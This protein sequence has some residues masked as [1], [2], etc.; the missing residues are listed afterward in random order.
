VA[1]GLGTVGAE[2]NRD[3]GFR[4]LG[5][6][7]RDNPAYRADCNSATARNLAPAVPWLR[8]PGRLAR[9]RAAWRWEVEKKLPA[10]AAA[11]AHHN[12]SLPAQNSGALTYFTLYF[13]SASH[14][15]RRGR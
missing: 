8:P 2:R 10:R 9:L 11:A 15:A 7:P 12:M 14:Q 4:R 13:T 5:R 6:R 3:P 1:G